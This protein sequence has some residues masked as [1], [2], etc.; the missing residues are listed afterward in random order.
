MRKAT[1]MS[2]IMSNCAS[3]HSAEMSPN[4]T[5]EKVTTM[6]YRAWWKSKANPPNAPS[7]SS[8]L[9]R[10]RAN[11]EMCP[12]TYPRSNVRTRLAEM[13]KRMK[14]EIKNQ[15][16]LPRSRRE[17]CGRLLASASAS[18]SVCCT[19]LRMR[20]VL[21]TWMKGAWCISNEESET[22][23]GAIATASST[24]CFE[25][26]APQSLALFACRPKR[27][28]TMKRTVTRTS[29]TIIRIG[30]AFSIEK[31]VSRTKSTAELSVAHVCSRWNQTLRQSRSSAREKLLH[32]RE[33]RA[34]SVDSPAISSS[35]S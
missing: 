16:T 34:E 29:A 35:I 18:V 5:V 14:R 20:A 3:A 32:T 1:T 9:G 10:P 8:G 12:P 23:P 21:N 15:I 19:S 22:N 30:S 28:S 6:K 17:Y 31:Y 33:P 26:I 13:N 25:K 7:P 27:T 2:K 4:P 24:I 11:H